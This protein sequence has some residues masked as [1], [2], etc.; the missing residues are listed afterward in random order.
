MSLP[1]SEI[2]QG[3]IRF[4]TD[5]Q[6]LEFYAQDQWWIM[7]THDTKLSESG[8][9]P[10]PGDRGF[11]AGGIK[12]TPSPTVYRTEID[13]INIASTGSTYDFGDLLVA[14]FGA[15]ACAS[16]T[17]ALQGQK[18]ASSGGYSAQVD[19][20]E[21]ASKGNIFDFGDLHGAKRSGG[22]GSNQT[23]GLFFGGQPGSGS[24]ANT[25]LFTISTLGSRQDF[26][27]MSTTLA[28]G[29]ASGINSPT[30]TIAAGGG[31]SKQAIYA[32]IPTTGS[33]MDF[34]DSDALFVGGQGGN[35]GAS[36]AT[37]GFFIVSAPGTQSD[38]IQYNTISSLGHFSN[39]GDL[40]DGRAS[41]SGASSKTRAVFSGGNDGSADS[42]IIDYVQ[43][44][45][46]GKAADFGDLVVTRRAAGGTS[47]GHGGL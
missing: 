44:S 32:T 7:S 41:I 38:V 10:T 11:F 35:S 8:A 39:F 2:P 5:S 47:N 18:E 42:N 30:R 19:A 17:R 31:S 27:D 25:D 12:L 37:R 1:P 20:W 29:F 16:R 46:T 6:R 43:I 9:E 26:G 40:T 24:L 22:G 15:S 23:R 28:E 21:I 14:A 45:T 13:A 34:P 4:N 3:A 36:N 33:W